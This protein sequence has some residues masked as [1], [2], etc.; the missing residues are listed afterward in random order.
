MASALA[1]DSFMLFAFEVFI[2]RGA[3]DEPGVDVAGVL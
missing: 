3:C 1:L 2:R